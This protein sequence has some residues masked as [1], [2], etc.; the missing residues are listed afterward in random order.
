M[1]RNAVDSVAGQYGRPGLS[2]RIMSAVRGAFPEGASSEDL[3]DFDHFHP[4]GRAA[5][6]ALAAAADPVHGSTVLDLGAGLGGPARWL[7]TH[8][9]CGVTCLDITPEYCEAAE[10][11]TEFTSLALLVDVRQGDAGDGR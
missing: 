4:G 5:T 2:E 10:A 8:F 7:A 6:E 9:G 1:S 3:G 11:L